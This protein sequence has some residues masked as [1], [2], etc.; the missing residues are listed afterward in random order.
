ME[1]WELTEYEQV[2]EPQ[3]VAMDAEMAYS[4]RP[5]YREI[6]CPLCLDI[7]NKTVTTRECLHRFCFSCLNKAFRNGSKE[8]PT[9]RRKLTSRPC[10]K[11]DPNF[12]QMI[13]RI[14]QGENERP[15]ESTKTNLIPPDFEIILRPLNDQRTR[16]LKCPPSTTIDHLSKY[17]SM[18][19]EGSKMPDLNRNEQYK[20]CIVANRSQG[21]YEM[22]SGTLNLEEIKTTFN[23]DLNKPLELY[24]YEPN[25]D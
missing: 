19:P 13:A 4:L 15:Q 2:R 21:H 1:T 9:C 5:L 6:I 18:R 11:E 3:E 14:N 20:L 12:D 7:L 23:L 8:C 10:Y 17:L 24:F 25:K 16:Y 22:L